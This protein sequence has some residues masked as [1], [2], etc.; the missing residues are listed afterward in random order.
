MVTVTDL[1]TSPLSPLPSPD[2]HSPGAVQVGSSHPPSCAPPPPIDLEECWQGQGVGGG[3]G[4]GKLDSPLIP[5][6]EV[7]SGESCLKV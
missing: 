7:E 6:W 3:R 1:P 2:P 4:S 5:P